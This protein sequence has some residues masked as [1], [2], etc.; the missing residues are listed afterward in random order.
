LEQLGIRKMVG[1]GGGGVP[2]WLFI[3]RRKKNIIPNQVACRKAASSAAL[4]CRCWSQ[5]VH[6]VWDGHRRQGPPCQ[7]QHRQRHRPHSCWFRGI[8]GESRAGQ[9]FHI[10]R[11]HSIS[12]TGAQG[13][14]KYKFGLGRGQDGRVACAIQAMEQVLAAC[15]ERVACSTS[16]CLSFGF[17][18]RALMM[19]CIPFHF[20]V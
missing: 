5:V 16:N 4:P 1:N 2:L 15:P 11:S 7:H 17:S 18:S 20:A 6:A 12:F 10:R 9:F 13:V 8:W 14:P 19:T 3:A